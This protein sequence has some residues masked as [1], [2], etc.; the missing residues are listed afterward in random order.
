MIHNKD[1]RATFSFWRC[2]CS[3][4]EIEIP[5]R[6]VLP[7][8]PLWSQRYDDGK[9]PEP[10]KFPVLVVYVTNYS[11]RNCQSEPWRLPT[12]ALE[13]TNCNYMQLKIAHKE[14]FSCLA[15]QCLTY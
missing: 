1:V 14:M 9:V 11:Q 6:R 7:V 3:L 8:G 15:P 2:S 10:Q 5:K 4:R 13:I 12:A